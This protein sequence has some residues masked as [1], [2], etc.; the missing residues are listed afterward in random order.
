MGG[1]LFAFFETCN[2]QTK[3]GIG[4]YSLEENIIAAYGT[5]TKKSRMVLQNYMRLEYAELGATF[6]VNDNNGVNRMIF[7]APKVK[8]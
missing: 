5:P 4:I 2:I 8:P 3:E 6:L 7:E 1:T